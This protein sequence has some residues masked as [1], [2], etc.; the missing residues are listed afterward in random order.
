MWNELN[1]LAGSQC[2]ALHSSVGIPTMCCVEEI[3]KVLVLYSNHGEIPFHLMN[4]ISTNHSNDCHSRFGLNLMDVSATTTEIARI[5]RA[6]RRKV[7][8][9]SG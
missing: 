9:Y 4:N 2:M 1:K 6:K 3:T 8:T 7:T 5:P